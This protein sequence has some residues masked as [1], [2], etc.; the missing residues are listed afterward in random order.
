MDCFT[1]DAPLCVYQFYGPREP[2][3]MEER[4]EKI[5]AKLRADTAKFI[6][7]KEKITP[8]LGEKLVDRWCL[9]VPRWDDKGVLENC[10]KAAERIRAATLAYAAPAIEVMIFDQEDFA[11]E[12]E[13]LRRRSALR[14]SLSVTAVQP[15]AI[16]DWQSEQPA[17]AK[18][19]R[20]K[21][22]RAYPNDTADQISS[23]LGQFV[24]HL[25]QGQNLLEKIREE[26]PTEAEELLKYVLSQE[27]T[28]SS[29]GPAETR[30][31]EILRGSLEDIKQQA[32]SIVGL[33]ANDA[34]RYALGQ[35]AD[36]IARCPLDWQ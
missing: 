31:V 20:E 2:L 1:L 7:Y 11:P 35:V 19:M 26:L 24:Q 28:L 15:N 30:P 17:L 13:M 4:T 34:Q 22:E 5:T 18:T 21:L 6:K 10:R 36:W 14:P 12:I 27:E 33:S 9:F 16:L 32:A 29:I 23:R 3:R 8:L 25:L